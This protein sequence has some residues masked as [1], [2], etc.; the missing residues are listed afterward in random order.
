MGFNYGTRPG[1][2]DIA[3]NDQIVNLFADFESYVKSK[4]PDINLS[5]KNSNSVKLNLAAGSNVLAYKFDISN[6]GESSMR[7]VHFN[8]A[9]S[10]LKPNG[11]TAAPVREND[12]DEMLLDLAKNANTDY[13]GNGNDRPI[14]TPYANSGYWFYHFD[15][16]DNKNLTRQDIHN[17]ISALAQKPF[18]NEDI[19]K[20]K[21]YREAC[22]FCMV[23]DADGL[24]DFNTEGLKIP[25][26]I[27]DTIADIKQAK[28]N[29]SL[30]DYH[31]W[32][33]RAAA[34]TFIATE[35]NL[36]AL[37]TVLENANNAAN[38]CGRMGLD[39][40]GS[41]GFNL[42]DALQNNASAYAGLNMLGQYAG[43]K[44]YNTISQTR[45]RD[46]ACRNLLNANTRRNVYESL[47]SSR[48]FEAQCVKYH[49]DPALHCPRRLNFGTTISADT[50]RLDVSYK[51][52]Y[53]MKNA[54]ESGDRTEDQ[55]YDLIVNDELHGPSELPVAMFDYNKD[56][57]SW[58]VRYDGNPAPHTL[59][60]F[61]NSQKEKFDF[62][63]AAITTPAELAG[64]LNDIAF[65]GSNPIDHVDAAALDMK[66]FSKSDVRSKIEKAYTEARADMYARYVAKG[67]VYDRLKM[68]SL[69]GDPNL[70]T[71]FEGGRMWQSMRFPDGW[72]RLAPDTDYEKAAAGAAHI[73]TKNS[74]CS[75]AATFRGKDLT[76]C[77]Y[78]RL[79]A[80][81][82]NERPNWEHKRF[83]KKYTKEIAD[84][85]RQLKEYAERPSL[86]REELDERDVTLPKAKFTAQCRLNDFLTMSD[87]YYSGKDSIF[88]HLDQDIRNAGSDG[89]MYYRPKDQMEAAVLK[90]FYANDPGRMPSR[91]YTKDTP[92]IEVLK[93]EYKRTDQGEIGHDLLLDVKQKLKTAALN[94]DSEGQGKY[95]AIIEKLGET[96]PGFKELD[97]AA[98]ISVVGLEAEN[99]GLEY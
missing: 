95:S 10:I 28:E 34:Q 48:N 33:A 13:V 30:R 82:E 70:F 1:A 14:G 79:Q 71:K 32:D 49:V 64:A 31:E 66:L 20:F 85:N 2:A 92:F 68:D 11:G 35:N 69:S 84:C 76:A 86:S 94:Y 62:I 81:P 99:A 6:L 63:D 60:E 93:D 46:T 57:N 91:E 40:T 67:N 41:T 27:A 21:D 96:Y 54:T 42:K 75:K 73:Q 7:S 44:K 52:Y 88:E 72:M 78:A 18:T 77:Q 36:N 24:A 50:P 53:D 19:L 98:A 90:T 26:R 5:L 97:H 45:Q 87:V 65:K 17:E 9:E 37:K 43:C 61:C 39:V 89:H 15:F 38:R 47:N 8:K 58:I 59:Q 23:K 80:V 55:Y 83:Y 12:S 56:A 3:L 51:L 4:L 16:E 74:F 29:S 25:K 22:A